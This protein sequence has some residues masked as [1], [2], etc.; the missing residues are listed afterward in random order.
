MYV[1]N[2]Q[3]F[4]FYNFQINLHTSKNLGGGAIALPAPPV[5]PPLDTLFALVLLLFSCTLDYLR[6]PASPAN[7]KTVTVL[8]LTLR[9]C[10]SGHA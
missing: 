5:D 4:I 2:S 6:Q 8:V 3:K 1:N 9:L 7:T 10:E